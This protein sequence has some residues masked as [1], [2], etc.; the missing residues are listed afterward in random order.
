MSKT[1]YKKQFTFHDRVNNV[2]NGKVDIFWINKRWEL[3]IGLEDYGLDTDYSE[4][5]QEFIDYCNSF[6]WTKFVTDDI[7]EEVIHQLDTYIEDIE[8][9]DE[10]RIEQITWEE[11]D[12]MVEND[13][14]PDEL[15][16][17]VD[18]EKL[19]ALALHL[20][21]TPYEAINDIS[22]SKYD[23]CLYEYGN[24]EYYV[25]TDN[26]RE[27][28]GR[29]RA[30]SLIEDCYITNEIKESWLYRHFDMESAIDEVIDDGYGN[31][32]AGYDSNEYEEEI[33]STDYFIYRNN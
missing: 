13:N 19:W 30:E 24:R 15:Q 9:A 32:F 16:D 18:D 17:I 33:N 7:E 25:Y 27:S 3:H 26:E 28:E 6:A 20:D 1:M 23:D 31:L 22:V 5:Q 4:L 29:E 21:I 8:E 2:I 11:F 12:T 10:D 14:I